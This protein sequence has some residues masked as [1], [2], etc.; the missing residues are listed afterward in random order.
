M[1]D[2]FT[3]D[4]LLA[5]DFPR[6]TGAVTIPMGLILARGT[7]LGQA[8]QGPGDHRAQNRRQHR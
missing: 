5:G 3:P 4:N 2:V 6:T 7:V 1:D 8:G